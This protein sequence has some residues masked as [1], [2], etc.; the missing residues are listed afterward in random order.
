[1]SCCIHIPGSC[2]SMKKAEF[3]ERRLKAF[4]AAVARFPHGLEKVV[5]RRREAFCGDEEVLRPTFE[6]SDFNC[7]KNE[8]RPSRVCPFLGS[9]ADGRHV[10]RLM[11]HL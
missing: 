10:E 11:L 5:Q 6:S 4:L 2:G 8:V 7:G 3:A 9:R 1:M